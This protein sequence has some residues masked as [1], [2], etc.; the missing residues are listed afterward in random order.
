MTETVW[1]GPWSVKKGDPLTITRSGEVLRLRV[2]SVDEDPD[3]VWTITT[4]LADE[5]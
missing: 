1:A 5:T 3:G 4:E 2:A